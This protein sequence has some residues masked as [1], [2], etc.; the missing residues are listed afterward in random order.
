MLLL[1][2][3]VGFERQNFINYDLY[4]LIGGEGFKR[5]KRRSKRDLHKFVP[6]LRK[7]ACVEFTTSEMG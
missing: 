3:A 2:D 7:T 4:L 5:E 1:D 6:V